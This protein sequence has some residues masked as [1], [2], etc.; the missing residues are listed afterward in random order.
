[1]QQ[2]GCWGLKVSIAIWEGSGIKDRLKF[3]QNHYHS[4]KYYSIGCKNSHTKYQNMFC[5]TLSGPPPKYE[6][7]FRCHSPKE[8]RSTHRR[9]ECERKKKERK[10]NKLQVFAPVHSPRTKLWFGSLI[11]GKGKT[12]GNDQEKDHPWRKIRLTKYPSAEDIALPHYRISIFFFHF[13]DQ[14]AVKL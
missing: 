3:S 9:V 5:D 11:E 13:I 10:K 8:P 1:M 6:H 14:Y 4:C 12:E 7:Y 2:H